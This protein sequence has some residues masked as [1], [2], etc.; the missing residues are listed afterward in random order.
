MTVESGS[1]ELPRL[2]PCPMCG[3]KTGRLEVM[4]TEV[5]VG[6]RECRLFL[7]RRIASGISPRWCA[8]DAIAAWNRRAGEVSREPSDEAVAAIVSALDHLVGLNR[9]ERMGMSAS[10]LEHYYEEHRAAKAE[11]VKLY[12]EARQV[13]GVTPQ[14]TTLPDRDLWDSLPLVAEVLRA[15]R[16]ESHEIPREIRCACGLAFG[17]IDARAWHR[18]AASMVMNVLAPP[19]AIA[20]PRNEQEK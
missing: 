5:V 11:V 17:F 2:E 8:A 13:S 9:R 12:R 10:V 7:T 1:N 20:A 15:H 18:H 3:A 4:V 14:T 19:P 6:C 16:P